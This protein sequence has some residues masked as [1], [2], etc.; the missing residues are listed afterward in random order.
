MCSICGSSSYRGFWYHTSTWRSTRLS[1]HFA[2]D[3]VSSNIYTV[4]LKAAKYGLTFW[5]L[6]D[7][8]TAYCLHHT[9]V[10][11]TVQ[12]VQ[13]VL[14]RKYAIKGYCNCSSYFFKR[15]NATYAADAT[16][17]TDATTATILASWLLRTCDS[18]VGC[19]C[20]V[21]FCV[22]CIYFVHFAKWK[23]LFSVL[24]KKFQIVTSDRTIC[25]RMPM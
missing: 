13:L 4:R 23:V 19:V 10:L 1:Y 17:G 2:A 5:C 21:L 20:C 24:V 22:C 16:D 11:T 12:F 18:C 8:S 14:E 3:A 9:L 6:C 7:A 15:H 25:T